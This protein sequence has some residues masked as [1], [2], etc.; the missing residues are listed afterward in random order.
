MKSLL[1]STKTNSITFVH[2]VIFVHSIEY[3]NSIVFINS[4]VYVNSIVFINSIIP[5]LPSSKPEQFEK[6]KRKLF[7]ML[8]PLKPPVA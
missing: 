1:P 5:S 7:A 3:V 8:N 4:I 6:I 2:S